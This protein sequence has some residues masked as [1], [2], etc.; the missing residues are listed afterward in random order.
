M[1][2]KFCLMATKDTPGRAR[3]TWVSPHVDYQSTEDKR[4]EEVEEGDE[5]SDAGSC[6]MQVLIHTIFGTT[7]GKTAMQSKANAL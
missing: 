1:F 7:A 2:D 4:A 5:K 3:C 6:A